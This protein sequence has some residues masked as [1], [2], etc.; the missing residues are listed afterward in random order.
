M[1]L[2]F[3]CESYDSPVVITLLFLLFNCYDSS[4]IIAL[5]FYYLIVRVIPWG[6]K[7]QPS[8]QIL[9]TLKLGSPVALKHQIT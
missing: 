2:L 9:F 6:F 3:D 4:F 5:C 7:P 8:F 1:F